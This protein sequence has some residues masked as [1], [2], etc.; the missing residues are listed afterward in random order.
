QLS[1]GAG[2][3]TAPAAADAATAAGADAAATRSAA[4]TRAAAASGSAAAG[5]AEV[6][7]AA[8]AATAG[9]DH[10][11]EAARRRSRASASRRENSQRENDRKYAHAPTVR[12]FSGSSYPLSLMGISR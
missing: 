5:I 8:S 7:C 3:R 12:S 6:E 1:G 11:D 2:R 10:V 9:P 4:A